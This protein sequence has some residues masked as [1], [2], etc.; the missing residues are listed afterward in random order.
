MEKI[1][2]YFLVISFSFYS[3][4]TINKQEI[5]C[6]NL[7]Y[8]N[9][10][11]DILYKLDKENENY[12]IEGIIKETIRLASL[13]KKRL[14][15][16]FFLGEIA[17]KSSN[18]IKNSVFFILSELYMGINKE[19]SL[20]YLTKISTDFYQTP[21]DNTP[22][23]YIIANKIIEHS[24]DY[25]LKEKTYNI[26][27][28]NYSDYIDT[29][30]TV[31]ELALLNRENFELDKA[32]K[33]MQQIIELSPNL[34]LND[35]GIDTVSLK[36]EI[37]VYKSSK[38]WVYSDV[39]LLVKEIKNAINKRNRY[40]IYSLVSRRNFDIKTFKDLDSSRWNISQIDIEKILE[41]CSS[42]ADKFEDFSTVDNLFL[43]A[44]TTSELS[45]QTIYFSFSKIDYPYDITI[46]GGWEWNGIYF[47]TPF[48]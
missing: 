37:E 42:F 11:E 45:G 13:E 22:I 40:L 33:R 47:G 27:L 30:T 25:K 46:N 19:L 39:N 35:T 44:D 34:N 23:G 9:R 29:T 1:V 4:F 20:F 21:Y 15:V 36:K 7:L 26:L 14:E 6:Y 38:E 2:F 24:S 5:S 41:N 16:I 31:Y 48:Y 28:D 12:S 18:I 43:K 3:C 17:E 10:I 8:K 32:I